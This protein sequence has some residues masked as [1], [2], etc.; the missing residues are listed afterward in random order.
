MNISKL[1]NNVKYVDD[2]KAAQLNDKKNLKVL[3]AAQLNDKNN[4]KVLSLQWTSNTDD[5]MELE[6]EGRVL[7]LLKPHQS[8]E[9]YVFAAM[10][11]QNFTFGSEI[12]LSQI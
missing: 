9:N 2:A 11:A 10:E 7:V 5:S 3:S 6:T 12:P 4:L 8:P 1:E